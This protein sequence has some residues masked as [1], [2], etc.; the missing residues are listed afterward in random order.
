M[1]CNCAGVW[2]WCGA[3]ISEEKAQVSGVPLIGKLEV[4]CLGP[5]WGGGRVRMGAWRRLG[6]GATQASGASTAPCFIGFLSL[7]PDP[8]I[9]PLPHRLSLSRLSPPTGC[10]PH[11]L[12][13]TLSQGQHSG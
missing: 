8:L 11:R 1:G 2:K 6:R 7:L 10:P 9:S 5:S 13:P 4:L 3:S 12:S